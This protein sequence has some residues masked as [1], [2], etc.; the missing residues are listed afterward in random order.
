MTATASDGTIYTGTTDADG[1]YDILVPVNDTYIVRVGTPSGTVPAAGSNDNTLPDNV[2]ENNKTHDGAGTTV[3][4]GTTDNLTLDFGFVPAASI[5]DTVWYDTNTN[6]LQDAGESGVPNIAV[7]LFDDNGNPIAATAT[8][9]NGHYSFKDLTPGDYQVVFDLGTLPAGYTVSPQD[10]GRDD[11]KDSDANIHTGKTSITT[12]DPGENDPNWDMGIK[13][14]QYEIGDLFWIDSNQNGVYDPDKENIVS[15]ATVE[16]FDT[17]G[18]LIATTRTDTEGHYHFDVTPGDYVVRFHMPPDKA[19]DGYVFTKGDVNGGYID[20]P[21]KVGNGT[22]AEYLVFDAAIACPCS[23]VEGDSVGM[24]DL[25][26][27]LPMFAVMV[28]LGGYFVR[29]EEQTAEPASF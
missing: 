27:L 2:S 29:R 4:V 24:S 5:G 12:L 22:S 20:M 6:G 26:S 21:A 16:L 14:D 28:L 13:R 10:Q 3:I 1:K 17:D 25:F 18:H 15:D 19:E 23:S 11:S 7:N 8:D 9:T